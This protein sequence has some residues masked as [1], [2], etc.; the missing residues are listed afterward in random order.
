[1]LGA[2]PG[3]AVSLDLNKAAEEI[4][5]VSDEFKLAVDAG[6]A[7]TT[8]VKQAFERLTSAVDML[9]K[10]PRTDDRIGRDGASRP[11]PPL[12]SSGERSGDQ[13]P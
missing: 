9:V 13:L 7:D 3:N 6:D 5:K 12:R 8:G 4:R 11:G 1:M 2:E 10:G